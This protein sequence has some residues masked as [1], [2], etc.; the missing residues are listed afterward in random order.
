MRPKLNMRAL[1]REDK[2]KLQREDSGEDLWRKIRSGSRS[3]HPEK[4]CKGNR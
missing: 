3:A 2:K 1:M 4:E